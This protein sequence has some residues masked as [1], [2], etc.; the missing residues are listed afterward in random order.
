MWQIEGKEQAGIE[1]AVL[2]NI[3]VKG[4]KSADMLVKT[5]ALASEQETYFKQFTDFAN[6]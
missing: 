6:E 3:F 1:Q 2:N 5:I 4:E